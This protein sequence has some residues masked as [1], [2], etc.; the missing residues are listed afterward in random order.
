MNVDDNENMQEKK[1]EEETDKR[2]KLEV[3]KQIITSNP[4]GKFILFSEFNPSFDSIKATLTEYN[5]TL[6]YIILTEIYFNTTLYDTF[7]TLITT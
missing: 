3:V 7:Y 5:I 2:T 1:E 4:E 6:F